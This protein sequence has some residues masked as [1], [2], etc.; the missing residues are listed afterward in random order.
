MYDHPK[1][2]FLMGGIRAGEA[3]L[4]SLAQKRTGDGSCRCAVESKT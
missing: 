1:W 2:V 4:R 3:L